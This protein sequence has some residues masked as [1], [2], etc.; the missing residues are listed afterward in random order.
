MICPHPDSDK[1]TEPEVFLLL[2]KFTISL[3]GGSFAKYLCGIGTTSIF[4][5]ASE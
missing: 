3:I 1:T 2:K 5:E 4:G